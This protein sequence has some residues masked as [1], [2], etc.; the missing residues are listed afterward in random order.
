MLHVLVY[1]NGSDQKKYGKPTSETGRRMGRRERRTLENR[2]ARH[3]FGSLYFIL[4]DIV[5]NI[6][7]RT[8]YLST[9]PN[10]E[11]CECACLHGQTCR[12]AEFR[13]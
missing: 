7:P 9:A 4:S 13:I 8:I 5:N 11:M 3:Q 12:K 6:L 2:N 10:N 1:V